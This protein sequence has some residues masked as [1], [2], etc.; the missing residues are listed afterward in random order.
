MLYS[1]S[2]DGRDFCFSRYCSKPRGLT[3]MRWIT[4]RLAQHLQ[5]QFA[6][7]AIAIAGVIHALL[8]ERIRQLGKLQAVALGD[9]AQRFIEVFVAD[10]DAG[11]LGPLHLHFLHDEAFE[12][13]LAHTFSGGSS[14]PCCF[15]RCA[16]TKACSSSS[17][18]ST[19]PSLT[20]AA[21]RSRR[22]PVLLV[23]RSAVTGAAA[24]AVVGDVSWA[25]ASD[26]DSTAVAS[27]R[28]AALNKLLGVM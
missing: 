5:R 20:M 13:L 28:A 23:A 11:A 15:R 18:S 22:W 19:I 27:V 9:V 4:S 2:S 24:G 21:T 12:H 14:R 3:L 17:L 25:S 16:I 1:F 10:A 6:A 8:R 7:Q 26:P